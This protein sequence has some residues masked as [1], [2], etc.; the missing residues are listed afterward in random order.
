MQIMEN[1]LRVYSP[2]QRLEPSRRAYFPKTLSVLAAAA[3]LALVTYWKLLGAQSL[4][5]LGAVSLSSFVSSIAGFAFSPICG[6]MLF[7]FG[8]EPVQLVQI[9][10]TCSIANQAAMSWS[11]RNHID[12]QGLSIFLLGGVFGI[13]VGVYVLL[14]VSKA[15]Y[16][17]GLGWFLI[18]YGTLMLLKKPLALRPNRLLDLSAGFIGGITGGAIGFPGG[19]VSIWCG[20]KGWNKDQQR[21]IFQP[22]IFIMQIV[23]LLAITFWQRHVHAASGYDWRYL[24][25]V[26]GALLGTSFGLQL[27]RR[28]SDVQFRRA[29]NV[30]LVISGLGYLL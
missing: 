5:V 13:P 25:C 21:A 14:A 1:T 10:I 19:P 22:F 12:W 11:M 18:L 2:Y 26:P 6:A 9:M 28:L 23:G 15:S 30:M 20:M 24:L 8:P 29:V 3:C 7:H 16:I 27:Y 4:P 17:Y